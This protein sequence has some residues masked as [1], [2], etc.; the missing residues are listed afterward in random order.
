MILSNKALAIAALLALAGATLAATT[1][2]AREPGVPTVWLVGDSTVHNGTPGEQGWGEPFIKMFDPAK[3]R[4]I[5]RAMGGRSSRTFQREGRWDA[6]LKDS[7][8]G[9]FVIIQMGHND[10]GP[11]SGD[12]RERG[13]I[14]GTGDDSKEVTLA[15]GEKETVHTYGWYMRKY[16]EDAKAK[17][18]TPIICSWI[19]HC[20]KAGE[21]IGP[22]GEANSYRQYAK[23]TA[24]QEKVPFI[25]L[26]ALTWHKYMKMTAED[27]KKTY[28]T[29][30]DNTHTNPVGA[31]VNAE[32]VVEGLKQ[33]KDIPLA[34]FL[35]PVSQ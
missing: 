2:P 1:E 21:P 26:Y 5:N 16:V 17:G 9:D 31:K 27:V 18:L 13:T 30:A 6:V 4:V 3:V 11:L 29:D 12:N 35:K 28:F 8:P 33:L 14:R 32:S 25:D 34:G 10:G 19:P 20:P 22:E 15:N 23:E 7:Q 24:E